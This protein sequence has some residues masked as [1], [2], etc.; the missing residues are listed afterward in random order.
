MIEFWK[1]ALSL[2][3]TTSWAYSGRNSQA[4]MVAHMTVFQKC[5][6]LSL[7]KMVLLT[8]CVCVCVRE[9]LENLKM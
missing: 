1:T 9:N 2:S 6:N 3:C 5:F 7:F 8:V 4:I